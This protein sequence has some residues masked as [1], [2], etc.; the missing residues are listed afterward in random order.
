[1]VMLKFCAIALTAVVLIG[2]LRI[3]RPELVPEAVLAASIL[4]LF[5][6]VG[7]IGQSFQYLEELYGRLSGRTA[8]FPVI[9]KTLGIAYVT[10]FTSAICQD[11][12]EKS[13]A[14]KVELAGKIAIFFSAL[15]VFTSLLDLLNTL[16]A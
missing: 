12:G 13:I 6:I 2:I 11:A 7:S 9:L 10:E 15:P 8:Y 5:Y 1:M 14:G 16:V 4:L 3:Y